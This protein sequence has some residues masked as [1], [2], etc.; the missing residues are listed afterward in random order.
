M[1]KKVTTLIILIIVILLS[2]LALA[3]GSYIRHHMQSSSGGTIPHSSLNIMI[4]SE[5]MSLNRSE[6]T[7]VT[8]IIKSVGVETVKIKIPAELENASL[9][10]GEKNLVKWDGN[11]N[12]S[13]TANLK[14]STKVKVSTIKYRANVSKYVPFKGRKSS[15][16]IDHSTIIL[17]QGL[18]EDL[19]ISPC[20]IDIF[21]NR[22]WI[23]L[24]EIYRSPEYKT[25]SPNFFKNEKFRLFLKSNDVEDKYLNYS[26]SYGNGFIENGTINN[27]NSTLNCIAFES[28]ILKILLFDKDGG[29]CEWCSSVNVNKNSLEEEI[30]NKKFIYVFY[31]LI[32]FI[33]FMPFRTIFRVI[34][35]P[36]IIVS[37]V[38]VFGALISDLNLEIINY[39]LRIFIF[40]LV[41]SS[42]FIENNFKNKHGT[43]VNGKK[44]ILLFIKDLLRWDLSRDQP[45]FILY[46][47]STLGMAIIMIFI[48]LLLPKADIFATDYSNQFSFISGYY[49]MLTQTF[50]SILGIIVAV[51]TG[52]FQIKKN[53]NENTSIDIIKNF[54]FLYMSLIVLSILGFAIGT[55]PPMEQTLQLVHNPL[56]RLA[57]MI[58]ESTLLLIIPAFACLYELSKH[59]IGQM[60]NK[61]KVPLFSPKH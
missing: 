51:T 28:S 54:V 19:N 47:T 33:I 30:R 45:D 23:E 9:L 5:D 41:Y 40:I 22:P 56:D 11:S 46:I 61:P 43:N 31:I 29:C 6:S 34:G 7:I 12:R 26:L 42:Y 15:L 20:K 10:P 37:G 53:N 52:F 35:W 4:D 50:G 3:H 14:G 59:T 13:F 1:T 39:E 57:I 18:G 27:G 21:N 32:I 16:L 49:N 36:L 2:P 25:E 24:V 44:D 38:P 55:V 58:F 8:Y 60:N 48:I 17:S